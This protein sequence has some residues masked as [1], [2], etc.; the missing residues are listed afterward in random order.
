MSKYVYQWEL[1]CAHLPGA[2]CTVTTEAVRCATV[3]VTGRQTFA[4]HRAAL[5]SESA[6]VA[7]RAF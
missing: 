6:D 1:T 4:R 5:A 7:D 3:N 2:A